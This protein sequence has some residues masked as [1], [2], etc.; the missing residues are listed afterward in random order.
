MSGGVA[1]IV[2]QPPS[3]RGHHAPTDR[4]VAPGEAL[5]EHEY[6]RQWRWWS[7]ERVAWLRLQV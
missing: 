5:R 7:R 1:Y 4:V 2:F 6:K 3:R